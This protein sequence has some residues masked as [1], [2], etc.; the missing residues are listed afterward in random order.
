MTRLPAPLS[1]LRWPYRT[2]IGQGLRRLPQR[3]M[4]LTEEEEESLL[5]KYGR[6]ALSG[7]ATVGH[8]LDTP[9]SVVRGMIA[10][11]PERA[12]GGILSPR[13]RVYGREMLEK[14]GILSPNRPGLD[15]GDVVGFG[16]EGVTD[17]LLWATMGASALTPAGQAV[18]AAGLMP[19]AQ[20]AMG[21]KALG[22]LGR[23]GAQ[24][25][26]KANLMQ[27]AAAQLPGKIQTRL[28][29][30]VDDIL[31][32]AAG[33]SAEQGAKA[34]KAVKDA[35]KGMGLTVD[36]I[37][38]QN[39]G[40]LIG[41]G[42]P[43]GRPLMVLGTGKGAQKAAKGMDYLARLV[44]KNWIGRKAG[45]LFWPSRSI[46]GAG[47]P[48]IEMQDVA[49]AM[50][51]VGKKANVEARELSGKM[52]TQFYRGMGEVADMDDVATIRKLVEGLDPKTQAPMLR[53]SIAEMKEV[54]DVMTP[55]L[56]ARGMKGSDLADQ[57]IQY[58][59]RTILKA[60]Q[61][62]AGAGRAAGIWDPHEMARAGIFKNLEKGTAQVI[63][64]TSDPAVEP[65]MEV[66]QRAPSLRPTKFKADDPLEVAYRALSGVFEQHGIPDTFMAKSGEKIAGRHRRLAKF[67]IE[68]TTPES[69]RLGLFAYHPVMD[70]AVRL[71]AFKESIAA[72]DTSFEALA[73]LSADS[74]EMLGTGVTESV[75]DVLAKMNIR[76][77]DESAGGLVQVGRRL[78]YI[79]AELGLAKTA[80]SRNRI[81]E[82]VGRRQIPRESA[83]QLL[84]MYRAYT[85]GDAA[86]DILPFVDSFTN[87]WKVGVTT[88]APAFHVRNLTS[89]LF[90]AWV[91]GTF[92]LQEATD[93]MHFIAGGEKGVIADAHTWP[94]VA[95]LLAKRGLEATPENGTDIVRQ[96]VYAHEVTGGRIGQAL[97]RTGVEATESLLPPSFREIAEALPGLG[98]G[99]SLRRAGQLLKG[100]TEE[101]T[102]NLL[103]SRV[104]GVGGALETT[105]APVRAGEELGKVVESINRLT[106]FFHQLRRGVDPAEAALRVALQQVDYGSR[107]FTVFEREVMKRLFPF[108]SFA[109]RNTAYT[110]RQLWQHPGGRMAQTIRVL[111]RMRDPNAALP[112]HISQTAAIPLPPGVSG[113][114]RYLTGIGLM[115][116]PAMEYVG[117]PKDVGLAI[118]SQLTPLVKGPLEYVTGQS[119][120]QRGPMGGRAL[121]EMDPPIARLI[122]NITPGVDKPPE[123]VPQWMEHL[124]MNLPLSRI[125]TTAKTLTD[126]RKRIRPGVAFPG[127]AALTNVMTGIRVTDVPMTA[128]ERMIK[129]VVNKIIQDIPGSRAFQ[130]FYIPAETLEQMPPEER[131]KGEELQNVLAIISR[132]NKERAAVRKKELPPSLY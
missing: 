63:R 65:I 61:R 50:H 22:A 21:V 40:G 47:T 132:H 76:L 105:F 6:M 46:P 78:G 123:F 106:P 38:Q 84:R 71:Q 26:A 17:P 91:D 124:A 102:W 85:R 34:L 52:I 117:A 18:K 93:A 25:I 83:D 15:V 103:K 95:E 56:A 19:T 60:R 3:V 100:G 69:R 31:K 72:A 121:G 127:A 108:Y 128:Q 45:Q 118:G 73:G 44:K 113:S 1:P 42:P 30:T 81:L 39:L 97:S 24:Q 75:A 20:K 92:G 109:S 79:D 36:A 13:K 104:R 67:L 27:R 57:F 126:P 58:W 89:G 55:E 122:A 33:E 35:A 8:V 2:A 115:F 64:A 5:R 80:A 32:F 116:E 12:F 66:L 74:A 131:A 99:S 54:L 23:K 53:Q 111:N 129:E 130:H 120:F 112:P 68:K 114:P 49:Q 96:L 119:F 7:L 51:N 9:G 87:L 41:I 107:A 59:A 82:A 86:A 10:G 11:E 98:R 14:G 43:F 101:S 4:P 88:I 29:A 90:R 48:S 70:N 62:G 77:G 125:L 94:K 110:L 37:R 16:A 28:A